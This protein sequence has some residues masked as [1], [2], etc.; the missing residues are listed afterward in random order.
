MNAIVQCLS[1]T[2][3]LAE[4]FVLEQYQHDLR[5]SKKNNK[6]FGTRGE[7]TEQ[8][9]LLMKSVWSCQYLPQHTTEF[10]RIVSKYSGQFRGNDQHDAQEF[11]IWLLDKVHEDLNCAPKKK[12]KQVKV[13]FLCAVQ[14]RKKC[15]MPPPLVLC[16]VFFQLPRTV[17]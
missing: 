12:Y 13:R 2:D 4:Y 6:K 7:V 16:K 15:S 17:S 3:M 14:R 11:L 10:K 1:N 9:A 8:L 5:R